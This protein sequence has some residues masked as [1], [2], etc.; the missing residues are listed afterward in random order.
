MQL[1]EIQAAVFSRVAQAS[2]LL[3]VLFDGKATG[4]YDAAGDPYAVV[5]IV[6]LD[7]REDVYCTGIVRSGFI[8]IRVHA[9]RGYGAYAATVEAEKFVALFPEGYTD[10][11]LWIPDVGDIKGTLDSTVDGW[12]YVPTTIYFEAR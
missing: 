4:N 12:F 10:G 1:S 3:P 9:K 6:P 11:G 8:F 7:N 2:N 5:S